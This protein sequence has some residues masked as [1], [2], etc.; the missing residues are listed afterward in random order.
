[1]RGPDQGNSLLRL[2]ALLPPALR[3]LCT[4]AP[5]AR[6]SLLFRQGTRPERMHYVA[7]GEVVLQRHG[8]RGEYVVLQRTR[9]GFVAEP[10]LQSSR[11]H[12]DAVVTVSG[13]VVS[14]P[15]GPFRQALLADPA[16]ALRWIGM[17][18]QEMK[19]LRAQCERLSLKGVRERLFHLIETEGDGGK[20]PLGAGL[21]S[22]ALELGVTHEALYRAV[23][24][25]EKQGLLE[26]APG[27]I[28]LR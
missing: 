22:I 12:C 6:G 27:Q 18:N 21:K 7:G 14:L 5:C 3:R 9:R 13:V 10:S 25:L 19:R 11:Y 23:A 24:D 20:L 8:L 15:I 28:A 17:L 4:S 26:R 1:M 2:D 16:F